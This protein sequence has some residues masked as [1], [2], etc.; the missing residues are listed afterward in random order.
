M[1]TV[2][3]YPKDLSPKKWNQSYEFGPFVIDVD[4]HLV[5]KDRQPVTLTPK[6][7]DTLLILVES[8]GRL[9]SKDQLMKALW[10]DS[11]VE[12][13]NLTQQISML[14][15][16]LGEV[17]GEYRYIVTVAGRGYRFA[18]EVKIRPAENAEMA[19]AASMPASPVANTPEA[20]GWPLV[21]D[22]AEVPPRPPVHIKRRSPN[23]GV[24][25]I[26]LAVLAL[27][28]AGWILATR[29][30]TAVD[31]QPSRHP[32]SLAILPFRNLKRDAD[33]DFLGLALAD[34]VIGK[35]S[36]LSELT[37]RPS[38]AVEK[39]RRLP[40]DIRGVAADLNVNTLLAGNFVRDGSDLRITSE[41]IDVKTQRILWNKVFDVKYEK[42]LTVQD[43]VAQEI[44]KGLDLSL[45]PSQSE[46][47]KS[48][49]PM[50]PLAYEYYLRGVDLYA[51]SDFVVAIKML[52]R[53]AQLNGDYA[54]TWAQL[55]RSYNA[56]ASFQFGGSQQ[57]R[58]AE[59]AYEKALALR[60]SHIETR[61]YMANMFTDTGRV[62]QAV[63]LL[64]E[65]L[66]TN[67]NYAEAHWELGYAYRFAG[68]LEESVAECERARQLDPGVKL[69]TSA[70][71]TYLYLGQYHKFLESLSKGD[72]TSLLVFYRG[73]GEYYKDNKEQAQRHFDRAFELDR[74]LLQGQVGKAISYGIRH[75]NRQGLEILQTAE[76]RI[77]ERGVGDP[78]AI[79]KVAQAYAVLGDTHS[80]LRVLH[81]S[82]ARGFFPCL[83]LE[84]DPLLSSVHRENEF[85][86]L[87]ATA[88]RRC[89]AFRKAFF[90]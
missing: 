37:V 7:Y 68:A 29:Q 85:T 58:K 61:V 44:V 69:N 75:Q 59:A 65:A 16:A 22:G 28:G 23:L 51:K 5:L 2:S 45:S 24:G 80:A 83:Y 53:S 48:G 86:T 67:P 40:I 66:K 21:G 27:A 14:R 71:N 8:G 19:D 13:S 73:L 11:F 38:S 4:R 18:E 1:G 34:A 6:T 76:S 35:L 63:P 12:E 49:Q 33:S 39:Y 72:E 41:L 10:P 84:H 42:L 17:F 87:M 74:S 81:Q 52:E 55:G 46:Q 30:R 64:R 36:Y 47:L 56:T 77:S 82:I 57:Y 70:T 90:R 60:P 50:D 26:V 43:S 54:P 31:A 20:S 62:E 3:Q 88:R 25:V 32:R 15:K 79:Y 9:L 78:E 89:N